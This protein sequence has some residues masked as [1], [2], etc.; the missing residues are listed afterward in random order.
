M[1]N[2]SNL[3]LVTTVN[4]LSLIKNINNITHM[5]SINNLSLV[6]T[7]I[8]HDMRTR[9]LR[10]P[11]VF[12]C[13]RFTIRSLWHRSLSVTHCIVM[14]GRSQR[15]RVLRRGSSVARLLGLRVRIPPGSWMSVSCDC[16]VLSGREIS[17]SGL[18]PV[19]MIRD[20][21]DVF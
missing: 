18:S 6:E 2:L 1:K 4:K 20:E 14:I 12:L 8:E 19:Q 10:R 5:K 17:A 9:V 11:I 16:C 3:S 13:V 7:I 15:R 21:C